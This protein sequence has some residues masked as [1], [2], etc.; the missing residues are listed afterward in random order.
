MKRT[1][2]SAVRRVGQRLRSARVATRRRPARAENVEH[3]IRRA[4][5]IPMPDRGNESAYPHTHYH[6]GE[7]ARRELFFSS[8]GERPCRFD[9]LNYPIRA[10]EI[11]DGGMNAQLS[12]QPTMTS[13]VYS[14]TLATLAD[15]DDWA[16]SKRLR[17]A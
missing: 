11:A 9:V 12:R 16:A 6:V 8:H 14:A 3:C 5:P 17:A 2:T 10:C 15:V 4:G 7:A 1:S 13:H